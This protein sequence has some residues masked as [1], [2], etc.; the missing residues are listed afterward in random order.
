MN[1]KAKGQAREIEQGRKVDL[2]WIRGNKLNLCFRNCEKYLLR[3]EWSLEYEVNSAFGCLC[4]DLG[5]N[6]SGRKPNAGE[7]WIFFSNQQILCIGVFLSALVYE[8]AEADCLTTSH[9][10]ASAWWSVHLLC[11]L[12]LHPSFSLFKKEMQ[13]HS[14]RLLLFLWT[15]R[16]PYSSS[17]CCRPVILQLPCLAQNCFGIIHLL[18]FCGGIIC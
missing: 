2:R 1:W 11:A 18:F 9:H 6:F 5:G 15:S 16:K 10:C 12:L 14:Y 17:S 3:G 8:M 13:S 4:L 7:V